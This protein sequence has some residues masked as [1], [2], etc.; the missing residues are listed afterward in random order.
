MRPR[1]PYERFMEKV[2]P[3]PTSGCWLWTARCGRTGYSVLWHDGKYV[4]AHRWAYEY[5]IG[6]VPPG[7]E[8]AH[9]CRVR[10]CVN[11]AHLEA[12]THRENLMRGQGPSALCSR[13]THCVH[14]HPFDAS[15][16]IVVEGR[17]RLCRSCRNLSRKVYK[18]R[19]KEKS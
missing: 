7:M 14:G 5:F 8:V 16:T 18:K 12:V 2:S 11:P 6:P 3:E 15:N 10:S 17:G 1:P 4:G 9:K 19:R 13:K